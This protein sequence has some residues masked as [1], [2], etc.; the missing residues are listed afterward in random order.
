MLLALR[1]EG[2]EESPGLQEEIRIMSTEFGKPV[3]FADLWTE[4]HDVS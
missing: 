4:V 1:L 2:W 3:V